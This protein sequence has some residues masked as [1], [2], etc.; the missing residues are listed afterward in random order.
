M[1]RRPDQG[2]PTAGADGGGA[3]LAEILREVRRIELHS[4]RL[5]SDVLAGGYASVFRGSGLEFHEV[6]E[7]AAGDD[8]RSIDWN[9]TARVGR[10]FV[11]TYVDERQLTVLFLLD[12]SASMSGGFGP[13]S[14]RHTAAR[15]AAALGLSAV[16]SGDKVGLVAFGAGVEHFV[17]PRKGNRQALRLVRDC[18]ALEPSASGTNLAPA[19]EFASRAVHGRAVLFVLSDWICAGYGPALARCARRHDVVA[20]R[21]AL[22]E[23]APP[24]EGWLR[25]RDPESGRQALIDFGSPTV[26]AAYRTRTAAWR[27][28]G[29]QV[30]RRARVDRIDVEVPRDRAR[31]VVTG[32]L[33]GFFRLRELRGGRR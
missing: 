16:K 26:R 21:L 6:R 22:P 11:K 1:S 2:R 4:R 14:A 7:Y 27:A 3:E 28:H 8:P 20:V 30:L 33:L 9:V 31:D 12:L 17:P 18:L 23:L 10:P 13:F 29:D 24:S 19:L 32:P 25:V 5:V 15:V